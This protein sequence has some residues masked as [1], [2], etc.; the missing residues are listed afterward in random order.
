MPLIGDHAVDVRGR[1]QLAIEHDSQP[2]VAHRNH[3]FVREIVLRQPAKSLGTRRFERKV[4]RQAL[5]GAH[6]RRGRGEIAAG[7]VVAVDNDEHFSFFADRSQNIVA[8]DLDRTVFFLLTHLQIDLDPTGD[9]SQ[10]G[11][12]VSVF[13]AS[14]FLVFGAADGSI[15][16]AVVLVGENAKHQHPGRADLSLDRV[17]LLLVLVG[18]DRDNDFQ[19]PVPGRANDDL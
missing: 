14:F 12:H 17:N 16:L 9:G 1:E 8:V 15:V 2:A 7:D 6:P 4:H 10:P 18:S 11:P 19:T 5:S 3:R 13:V